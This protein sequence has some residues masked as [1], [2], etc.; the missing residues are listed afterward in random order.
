[1]HKT[2]VLVGFMGC[3]KT[4]LGQYAAKALGMEFADTDS[5]IEREAGMSISQIFAEQGEETFRKWETE[6]L[7]RSCQE[8]GKILAT[9]G[10][11]IKNPYNVKMLHDMDVSVVWLVAD[12]GRIYGRLRQDNTRP[13]LADT[14]GEAKRRRIETLLAEREELYKRAAQYAFIEEGFSEEQMGDAFVQ[15]LEREIFEKDGKKS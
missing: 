13:L 12:A 9:G 4:H 1:M 15:W 14:S 2:I 10:G 3:G 5:L 6:V 7:R 11:V 8:R